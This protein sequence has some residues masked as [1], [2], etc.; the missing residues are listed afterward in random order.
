M[1][2]S[3]IQHLAPVEGERIQESLGKIWAFVGGC[4]LVAVFGG[5]LF[6]GWWIEFPL[7]ETKEVRALRPEDQLQMGKL[8]TI[9]GKEVLEVPADPGHPVPVTTRHVLGFGYGAFGAIIVIAGS[10]GIAVGSGRLIH[11]SIQRPTLIIGH[12]CFQLVVRDTFVK[13]QVPYKNIGAVELIKNERNGKPMFIGVN[14]RDLN[15][16]A[17]HYQGAARSKSWTGW[18]YALGNKEI[19]AVSIVYIYERLQEAMKRAQDPG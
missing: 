6:W 5:L 12:T 10:V 11:S 4:I 14:L 19:Y 8:R 7:Y 2:D 16:P 9:N 13:L 18:D 17:M 15:D 3:H 1:D